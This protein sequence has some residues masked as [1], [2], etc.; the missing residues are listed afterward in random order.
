[1]DRT[2]HALREAI[3]AQCR[4][5][6]AAGLGAGTAGNISARY[7]ARMLI[8]PTG[9]AYDE[10]QPGDIA[11]TALAGDGG[12]WDGP[13]GPSSEWRLHL[14][15]LQARPEIGAVVHGH[16]PYAT[17]LAM[18]R[19]EIP[20]C[21]YMVAASGGPSIRCADYA[22]FGTP[23]L[24]DHV[25]RA[26][27]G[28]TCCLMANHGMIATGADLD[29]AMWL[30]VEVEELARQYLLSLAAGGPV[31]LPEAEIAEVVRRF[32]DYGPKSRDGGQNGGP[33]GGRDGS[34]D[35]GAGPAGGG[36]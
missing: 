11:S 21:H 1:M 24:S 27:D 28:R 5:M 18:A 19:R 6:N 35:G 20:A 26:L 8:T 2:E 30:A 23:E 3:V 7:G 9:V 34:Q 25:L 12:D 10:M 13:L 36:A 4:F 16:P 33:D 31:L 14:G 32:A 22:T 15:I 17:A 29:Q